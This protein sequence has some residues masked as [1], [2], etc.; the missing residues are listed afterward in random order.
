MCIPQSFRSSTSYNHQLK[1]QSSTLSPLNILKSSFTHL[2]PQPPLFSSKSVRPLRA[3]SKSGKA[4]GEAGEVNGIANLSQRQSK[5]STETATGNSIG[6]SGNYAGG[7]KLMIETY[8]NA[9]GASSASTRSSRNFSKKERA[10]RDSEFSRSS[11]R[12]SQFSGPSESSGLSEFSKPSRSLRVSGSAGIPE[13]EIRQQSDPNAY[14]SSFSN[15]QPLGKHPFQVKNSQK[16]DEENYTIRPSIYTPLNI[17]FSTFGQPL[18]IPYSTKSNNQQS[19]INIPQSFNGSTFYNP[20]SNQLTQRILLPLN[21]SKSS[22]TCITPQTLIFS[23]PSPKSSQSASKTGKQ[24]T[25]V[26]TNPTDEISDTENVN[27]IRFSADAFVNPNIQI[28]TGSHVL[29]FSSQSSEPLQPSGPSNTSGLSGFPGSSG[30]SQFSGSSPPSGFS[31]FP[32][33]SGLSQFS[34]F[35]PPSGFS[36]PSGPSESLIPLG[37]SVLLQFSGFPELS[38]PLN[39]PFSEVP[40]GSP[41]SLGPSIIPSKIRPFIPS[42]TQNKVGIN[43]PTEQAGPRIPETSSLITGTGETQTDD[44][45]NHPPHIH[46][47]NVECSKTMMTINVEFNRVFDG[48]IYSKGYYSNPE[49]IYVKQNSGS[50]RYSFT[51]NLDS[52]GTQFINDF[53]GP[54]GQAYLENVL[55]LQNE[56]SIQEVWDTVRRVR[57]LWEGN[58]N[59]TLRMNLS[60]DMLNQEIIAF[61]GD[62]AVTKLGIQIGRGPF[63]PIAN[64]LIKIGETMTLVIS[65]EGDSDFDLQVRDCSARDEMSTNMLQLTDERGCTLKPKL[66]GAFQKTK[67]TANTGASVIAYAF[68]QAFKFPDVLGVF[69]ECNV[70]LCKTNCEPCPEANQQIEP[71]RRRRSLMNAPSSNNL[72]NSVPLSDAVRVGRRFKVIML[73]DLNIASN[74]IL[75]ST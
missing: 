75:D 1:Q 58:I 35:S 42:T 4:L 30:L 41:E 20:Q 38:K 53:T 29:D 66:F 6:I 37:P 51:V 54:A 50:T 68:F 23:L 7:V 62:T 21:C 10:L 22:S 33:S 31:G 65:V 26:I 2:S 24:L 69:I 45:F 64:G 46:S 39:F 27:L 14:L 56:P 28:A 61:N 11:E 5:S 8:E 40:V 55:V 63:A 74:Q 73:D 32:G 13:T 48:I 70:E 9:L 19:S 15:Q 36:R 71:G 16:R 18:S 67:D 44:D 60:V 59:Q 47:I 43:V 49:C 12:L 17:N 57:C 72:T 3:V 52:C 34:G 25:N